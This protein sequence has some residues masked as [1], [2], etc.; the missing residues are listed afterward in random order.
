MSHET[1]NWNMKLRDAILQLSI[2]L[3]ETASKVI[4]GL[5]GIEEH[6]ETLSLG[7]KSSSL[8]FNSKILLLMDLGAINKNLKSKYQAFMEI[9]NKFIHVASVNSF[10]EC[11]KVSDGPKT[12]LR[13]FPQAKDLELEEQY[14][15]AFFSLFLEIEGHAREVYTIISGRKLEEARRDFRF[16]TQRVLNIVIA[17]YSYQ[18]EKILDSELSPCKAYPSTLK[19]KLKSSLLR[20]LQD[21]AEHHLHD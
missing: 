2:S 6:E 14:E 10:V 21:C 19:L 4:A 5:L 8:S 9:R 7:S 1:R 20:A 17:Q 18:I 11:A 13:A 3:E 16:D 15:K 12:M